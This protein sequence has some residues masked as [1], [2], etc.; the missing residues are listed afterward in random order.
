MASSSASEQILRNCI[1]LLSLVFALDLDDA[2]KAAIQQCY[3]HFDFL[4]LILR[5]F[6]EN[7][8]N[9]KISEAALGFITRSVLQNP[10]H[11]TDIQALLPGFF[12]T[13]NSKCIYLHT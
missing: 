1:T 11:S 10:I 7:N 12:K 13:L 5:Y 3:T 4:S 9:L 6:K 2:T 8:D